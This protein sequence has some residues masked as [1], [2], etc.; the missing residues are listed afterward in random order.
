MG[1]NA[2]LPDAQ[3]SATVP[4]GDDTD[5]VEEVEVAD[6]PA[7]DVVITDITGSLTDDQIQGLFNAFTDEDWAEVDRLID[8]FER[9]GV[10][11][12]NK[13]GG[14]D[15]NRG[16]AESF[17][18]PVPTFPISA[19]AVLAKSAFDAPVLTGE[20]V[21]GIAAAAWPGLQCSPD[22]LAQSDYFKV[23]GI[24]AQSDTAQVVD[25]K[26]VRDGSDQNLVGVPVNLY[27]LAVDGHKTVP[28]AVLVAGP[29][30]AGISLVDPR[31]EGVKA[32]SLVGQIGVVPPSPVASGTQPTGVKGLVAPAGGLSGSELPS[33]TFALVAGTTEATGLG[34]L[35][36]VKGDA[37]HVRILHESKAGGVDRNRGSA[38]QLR[39]YWTV[40]EGAA[41][42]QWGTSGD[43]TRCVAHLSKYL[44]PRAKGYCALRHKERNGFY[45]GS[46][47]NKSDNGSDSTYHE[48]QDST[49]KGEPMLEHK[50]V[51]LKG[52]NIVDAEAGIVETII[53]VTGIVDNVKDRINPGAYSKTLAKR[54]P[55]GVWS[56]DWDTPVSK[57]L[58]VRELLP[59]DPEL[60]KTMPNG[61]PWPVNAGALK[62]KTQFNLDTQR[63]R[64]AYSDVTFF[65]DE[66][67]WSIGYNVPVGGAKV[68]Q[69]S[70]V[71]EIDT[72][73]LYEYSPV[74]FGAMPLARTT[75]VKEAQMALKALKG[76]AASWLAEATK[77]DNTDDEDVEE[78]G[79]TSPDDIE[80]DIVA[81]LDGKQYELPADQMIL[82]KRAVSTLTDLLAVVQGD[83]EMKVAE[84][85][86]D[87]EDS[88]VQEYDSLVDAIDDLV[89]DGDVYDALIDPANA[90][91]QAIEDS[92]INALDQAS[93]E[94]LDGIQ[95]QMKSGK[96]NVELLRDLASTV[97][98]LIDQMGGEDTGE[99]DTDDEEMPS[100]DT[101]E[102][103][104]PDD[105]EQGSKTLL[106][107]DEIAAFVQKFNTK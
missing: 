17:L 70:G 95:A 4:I 46:K 107:A 53:S 49:F 1:T 9:T 89:D 43:W 12:D 31:D 106:S 28:V 99:D 38:E 74:L 51:S 3:E 21:A 81:D 8:E 103:K 11:T 24:D 67:E 91:D 2:E 78:Y 25:S 36:A 27:R 52:M 96:G 30:P 47:L 42:I 59:G 94:F 10:Y 87:D 7:D 40:G 35:V 100:E 98:D 88:G 80:D 84:D 13:A 72:L 41:K 37:G 76:G 16:G 26:A 60:P 79:D 33:T 56:H 19:S 66:Q 105:A 73:E 63:G 39:H 86:P 32:F 20:E 85:I 61:D 23:I 104:E 83:M 6:T 65:A 14:I 93:N 62:V 97:A 44:G 34:G 58:D 18:G 101:I 48:T 50:V 82:V 77:D 90:I 22:V 15:R 102:K 45:P 68:D 29:Q 57:T 55:K 5:T 71:R 64:E 54:K 69:K 75:S 92:D